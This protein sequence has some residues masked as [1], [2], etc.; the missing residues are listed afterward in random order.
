MDRELLIDQIRRKI[1]SARHIL[2]A[3]HIRPDGDAVGSLLGMGLSLEQA[4]KDVQMV[5][6]DGIPDGLRFLPSSDKILKQVTGPFDLFIV[7]DCADFERVGNGLLN[8]GIPDINVDHHVTNTQF[9]QLNLVDGNASATA[10]ILA[11][12]LPQFGLKINSDIA[13]ALLTGIL[14]D[15]I[16]FR[17]GSVT[18]GTLRLAADLMDIG[19][20]LPELYR[21]ALLQKTTSAI[22]YWGQGLA[23][24][25]VEGQ[26]VWTSLTLEDREQVDYPGKDDADLINVL[27]GIKDIS[28]ALIFVEQPGGRVKVSWRSQNGLDVSKIAGQFGGGGHRAAA[29][30][31]IEGTLEEVQKRVLNATRLLFTEQPLQ[32]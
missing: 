25:H 29:G 14:T 2:V 6:L 8:F 23:D 13:S 22:R 3:S 12:R 27:S 1:L 18:P 5:L 20:N 24:L 28:I 19:A 21:Q 10:E 7:V 17:V 16:G 31:E 9:A 30:A 11:T 15:T 32:R 26:I 4:G